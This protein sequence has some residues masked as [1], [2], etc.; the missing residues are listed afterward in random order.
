MELKSGC[1][2]SNSVIEGP[3]NNCIGFTR[4]KLLFLDNGQLYGRVV[5]SLG[6]DMLETPDG[7]G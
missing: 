4:D 2:G 6:I 7:D 3:T 5:D 1:E